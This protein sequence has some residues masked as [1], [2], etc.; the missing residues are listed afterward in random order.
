LSEVAPAP[1]PP[2]ALPTASAFA[3]G[4]SS[5]PRRLHSILRV[6]SAQALA[7]GCG[8]RAT[9][10]SSDRRLR[11]SDAQP[12]TPLA[13]LPED[14]AA[15]SGAAAADADDSQRSEDAALVTE[16]DLDAQLDLQTINRHGSMVAL[17]GSSHHLHA[18]AP[19]G[20][21]AAASAALAAAV[22]TAVIADT[23]RSTAVANA[24]AL[25]AAEAAHK[26]TQRRPATPPLATPTTASSS[27]RTPH[28][29]EPQAQR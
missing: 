20:G 6:T 15:S 12:A 7:A 2:P 3:G 8:P 28:E 10:P 22:A 5:P 11:I 17:L 18:H 27:R 16:M 29:R 4:C 14:G 1:A 25:A 19:S 23:P 9:T 13:G 26:A 24:L 21:D